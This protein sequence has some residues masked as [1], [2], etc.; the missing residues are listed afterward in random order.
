MNKSSCFGLEYTCTIQTLVS[1]R[2]LRCYKYIQSFLIFLGRFSVVFR[3]FLRKWYNWR[4]KYGSFLHQ[5]LKINT[6]R[7]FVFHYLQ[8]FWLTAIFAILIG[9]IELKISMEIVSLQSHTKAYVE[10]H[11]ML[12]WRKTDK[13]WRSESA[14]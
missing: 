4:L 8:F 13:N 9:Y 5:R 1:I 11:D 7:Y 10:K 14:V 12:V 6:K 3:Y 2:T